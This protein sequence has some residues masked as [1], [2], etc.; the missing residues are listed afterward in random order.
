MNAIKIHDQLIPINLTT[1][2]HRITI[3]KQSDE[4]LEEF[5]NYELCPH[6]V[7]L[8]DECGMR[9]AIKSVSYKAFM[10]TEQVHHQ[11]CVHVIDLGYFLNSVAWS[12]GQTFSSIWESYVSFF[13]NKYKDSF[14]VVFDGYP[15]ESAELLSIL[16]E[17]EEKPW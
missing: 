17:Q 10:P 2:F 4:E 7:S 5:L 1:T 12:R 3:A 16:R 6:P 14:V 8:F 13:K 11:D 9:K 15:E